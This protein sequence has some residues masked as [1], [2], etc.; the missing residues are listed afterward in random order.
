MVILIIVVLA[1]ISLGVGAGIYLT[2]D[3]ASDRWGLVLGITFFGAWSWT[4]GLAFARGN[5]LSMGTTVQAVVLFVPPLFVGV[6]A[7]AVQQ[8]YHDLNHPGEMYTLIANQ[9]DRQQPEQV[10]LL[11][12]FERG[13]LVRLPDQKVNEFL[14]GIRSA[15]SDCIAMARAANRWGAGTSGSTVQI[16]DPLLPTPTRSADRRASD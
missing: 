8:G 7:F 11:R 12:T 5:R 10:N 4:W 2:S 13:V 3:P 15:R 6:I 14:A 1:L 9:P 16:G